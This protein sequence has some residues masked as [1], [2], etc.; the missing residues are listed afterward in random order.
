MEPKSQGFEREHLDHSYVRVLSCLPILTRFRMRIN[1]S[2]SNT[3]IG[4]SVMH[5]QTALTFFQALCELPCVKR[6]FSL[7]E[8]WSAFL[9]RRLLGTNVDHNEATKENLLQLI[10]KHSFRYNIC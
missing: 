10:N 7:I 3:F 2:I 4:S 6:V 1:L 8:T 9:S 5:V